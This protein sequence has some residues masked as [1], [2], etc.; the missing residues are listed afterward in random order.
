MEFNEAEARNALLA[1]SSDMAA[2]IAMLVESSKAPP[3][4]ADDDDGHAAVPPQEQPVD[5]LPEE[6]QA[7]EQRDGDLRNFFLAM[8][9]EDDIVDNGSD[10]SDED[11]DGSD[12]EDAHLADEKC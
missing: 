11:S 7:Q 4:D 2:A 10:V 3:Q 1:T 5:P 9:P 8:V 6:H 12:V